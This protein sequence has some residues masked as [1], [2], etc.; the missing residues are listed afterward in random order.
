[1]RE[2]DQPGCV[3]GE[4]R[5]LVGLGVALI[6]FGLGRRQSIVGLRGEQIEAGAPNRNPAAAND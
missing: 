2:G 6:A 1:M 4:A 5:L 3:R